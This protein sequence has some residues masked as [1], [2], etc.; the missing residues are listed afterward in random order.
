MVELADLASWTPIALNLTKPAPTI[1]WADF[2]GERFSDP[3]F[4]QTVLRL[5]GGVDPRPVIRTEL[6]ALLSLDRAP[7][8]APSGMIFHLS[9]CGST[10]L[11][12]LLATLPG[13]VVVSEPAPLNALLEADP[14][15][16][17]EDVQVEVARLLV[18]A[19]GR[20]R[21]GDERHL[22]LK[23]SSWNVRRAAVLTRA[24]PDAPVLWLQRRPSEVMA[25]L[26]AG[27]PGWGRVQDA[28]EIARHLFDI[29][30]GDRSREQ[31]LVLALAAMLDS[32][33]SLVATNLDYRDL[34]EAAWALVAGLFGLP[35]HPE[36]IVRMRDESRFS[37]KEPGRIPF[38]DATAGAASLAGDVLAE[39][40]ERLDPRYEAVDGGGNS[41]APPPPRPSPVSRERED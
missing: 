28:P 37:A 27:P 29:A 8:L 9:R 36:H 31:F 7:S 14:E 21:L 26:L 1:D 12:R 33:S 11:S 30:A 18:R 17:H 4:G 34:P 25:S 15:S 6:D 41:S 39:I 35:C 23:L 13:V 38:R 22:V 10:L 20:V 40:E 24:F 2:S 32:A 16:I 3:F 5:T 19:L